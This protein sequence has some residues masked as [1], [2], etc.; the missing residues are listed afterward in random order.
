MKFK[1]QELLLAEKADKLFELMERQVVAEET[2]AQ[3]LQRQ[4]VIMENLCPKIYACL[5][6]VE[7][8]ADKIRNS[9]VFSK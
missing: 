7:Y 1:D 3:A 4:T 9:K 2:K 8:L 6:S 5:L